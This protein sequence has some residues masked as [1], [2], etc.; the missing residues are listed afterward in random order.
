MLAISIVITI[1]GLSS[2]AHPDGALVK[3]AKAATPIVWLVFLASL[4]VG[5]I[6]SESYSPEYKEVAY[7]S[8]EYGL[9]AVSNSSVASGESSVSSSL[10]FYASSATVEERQ[11]L[12]YIRLDSD[13]KD[14]S[15]SYK[16]VT[17]W[18]LDQVRIYEDNSREPVEK[19]HH[20]KQV[21]TNPFN[22]DETR[23]KPGSD[24]LDYVEI[25]IPENSVVHGY[26]ISVNQG[27]TS[28]EG[29]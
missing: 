28:K 6:S 17:S 21:L 27:A 1:V 2:D 18:P 10:L 13:P 23:D 15:R 19:H 7:V 26:N 12:Q 9:V 29:E 16:T 4:L 14:S 24:R 8:E 20:V 3:K 22:P 5:I 25:V 11:V